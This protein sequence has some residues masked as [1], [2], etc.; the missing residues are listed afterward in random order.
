MNHSIVRRCSVSQSSSIASNDSMKPLTSVA[1]NWKI[2]NCTNSTKK[3][4]FLFQ[5]LIILKSQ[6]T[7][8]KLSGDPCW[9]RDPQVGN[10]WS[11]GS[12][13]SQQPQSILRRQNWGN[14]S[15]PSYIRA[16]QEH[17]TQNSRKF[18]GFMYR[19]EGFW[20]QRMSIPSHNS[21]IH[22]PGW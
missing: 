21:R 12:F 2:R 16:L 10:R 11:R 22:V 19:R 5:K 17:C 14:K 8:G 3:T 18:P 20:L 1:D 13:R 9:G 15:R 7:P 4:C 6:A